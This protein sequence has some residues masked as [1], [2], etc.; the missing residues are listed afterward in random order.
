MTCLSKCGIDIKVT[1]YLEYYWHVGCNGERVPPLIS[2]V[3]R[4]IMFVSPPSETVR[5]L[6]SCNHLLTVVRT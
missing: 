2:L 6:H 1:N 5:I 3:A 4:R